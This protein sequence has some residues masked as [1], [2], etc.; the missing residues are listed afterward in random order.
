MLEALE[1]AEVLKGVVASSSSRPRPVDIRR[2]TDPGDSMQNN[3][4]YVEKEIFVCSDFKL[5]SIQRKNYS[6]SK[7]KKKSYLYIKSFNSWI[8]I[9]EH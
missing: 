1:R 3:S 2:P 6:T 5:K 8:T 7:N 9:I 4:H